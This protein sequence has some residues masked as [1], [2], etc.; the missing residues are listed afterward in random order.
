MGSSK[1]KPSRMLIL[2]TAMAVLLPLLAALQYYWL[3]QVSEGASERLQSALR[4]SATGFRHDFNREFI[5]AYLN[6]QIDS[7]TPPAN[8]ERY[9]LDRFEQWNQAAPYPQL[10]SDVF[11]VS[12]DEQ[13]RPRLSHLNAKTK[14]LELTE[15][16]GELLNLV[17]RF[18]R[19]D[20]G[21]S[22]LNTSAQDSIESFAEEIPALIVPFPLVPTQK[23]QQSQDSPLPPGFTIIK[24]DLNYIQREFIP[25][26]LR[27]HLF[28]DARSEY[29][30][31]IVS[32]NHPERVI[33]SSRNPVVDFASSDVSTRVFGLEA[34]EIRTFLSIEGMSPAGTKQTGPRPLRL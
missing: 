14:R 23:P 34:D 10:I 3:G 20:D 27:R 13:G 18:D 7:F 2:L 4:A 22:H 29:N 6:F 16:S 25:S 9:H 26:L 32:L 21:S 8:I 11:V 17:N 28:D 15:W 1:Y 12:Y 5:R 33:Y 30:V 19:R 24:L 31:A